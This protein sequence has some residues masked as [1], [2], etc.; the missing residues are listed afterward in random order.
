[1]YDLRSAGCGVEVGSIGQ[2]PEGTT[3]IETLFEN[4]YS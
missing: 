2:S 4:N 3:D 1:M